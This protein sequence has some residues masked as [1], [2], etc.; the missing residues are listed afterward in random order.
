MLL[1][2]KKKTRKKHPI[3]NSIFLE[4]YQTLIENKK[5]LVQYMDMVKNNQKITIATTFQLGLRLFTVR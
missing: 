2:T 5:K 3:V 1:A 4:C